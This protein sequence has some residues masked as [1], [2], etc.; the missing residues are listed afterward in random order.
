M[1]SPQELMDAAKLFTL[2]EPIRGPRV[3]IMSIQA[4][5]AIML[6]D[7]CVSFG[8]EVARFSEETR[9]KVAELLPP[10]TYL[11]NPVDMGFFWHPPV[12]VEVAKTLIRDPQVDI[13][14]MY[15]LAAAGPMTDIMRSIALETLPAR[16]PGKIL[17][18]GTDIST[19]DLMADLDEIQRAG[20]PVYLAPERA[21]RSLVQKVKYERIRRHLLDEAPPPGSGRS[22]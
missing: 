20:V 9:R 5:A 12:F 2:Q 21:I 8:L 7:L 19:Y 14:I 15:S 3:A 10:K 1:E 11:D 13:L 4:G 18:F 17:M 16:E 6:T 22:L